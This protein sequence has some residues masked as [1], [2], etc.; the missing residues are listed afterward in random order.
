MASGARGGGANHLL[1]LLPELSNLGI[2]CSACVGQDGP[3]LESLRALGIDARAIELMGLR[4]DARKPSRVN[5]VIQEANADIVHYHGTRAAFFGLSGARM[6]GLC[7]KHTVYTAHGLSYRKE[8]APPFKALYTGIESFVCRTAGMVISVSRRDLDDLCRRGYVNIDHGFHLPNAVD[9][10]RFCPGD[11]TAAREKIGLGK[12]QF[13]AGTV[14]RLVPQKSVGDLIEAMK[15]CPEQVHL[16]IAGDG[17]QRIQLEKEATPLGSRVHFLGEREDIPDLLRAWNVFVLPSR[18]EGEPI[19]LLEA[20]ATGSA[21]VA[22]DTLGSREIVGESD[23]ALLV[24]VGNAREIA[25][26]I[27][28]LFE[29]PTLMST[30]GARAR[31]LMSERSYPKMAQRLSRL[32]EQLLR[33]PKQKVG[34]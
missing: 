17:P 19:S 28:R 13:W 12:E 5:R 6:R 11:R 32:Y 14:S 23:A 31:K 27:G 34:T 4:S 9:T 7:T 33:T 10:Q 29:D 8:M 2:Q 16:C 22:T 1:G 24:E 18:W 15:H 26:G 30:L 25:G 20:M 21:C 3:T